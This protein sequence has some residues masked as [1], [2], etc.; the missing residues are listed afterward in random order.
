[1]NSSQLLLLIVYCLGTI[2]TFFGTM[3]GTCSGRQAFAYAIFW[4]IFGLIHLIIGLIENVMDI[5]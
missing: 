5:K 2:V 3:E 4:P 1:M